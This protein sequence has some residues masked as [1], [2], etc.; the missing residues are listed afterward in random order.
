MPGLVVQ[1]KEHLSSTLL[2]ANRILTKREL[3]EQSRRTLR[4]IV[5]KAPQAAELLKHAHWLQIN[6][7][8]EPGTLGHLPKFKEGA[9]RPSE[10]GSLED[11]IHR[12][13]T[14]KVP[15]YK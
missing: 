4:K 7:E 12:V 15:Y 11:R 13:G 5:E 9:A 6:E 14:V 8:T 2:R 3:G 1:G 10:E